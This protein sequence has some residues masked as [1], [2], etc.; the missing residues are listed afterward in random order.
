MNLVLLIAS[1]VFGGLTV[2][3][4]IGGLRK[5]YTGARPR[6]R[7]LLAATAC[8]VITGILMVYEL[9]SSVQA[10]INR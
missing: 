8:S 6:A 1:V 4:V 2:L 10:L 7:G 3:F 9:V 5:L